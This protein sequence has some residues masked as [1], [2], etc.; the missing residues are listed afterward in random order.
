MSTI[1]AEPV[2]TPAA[3]TAVADHDVAIVGS[4]FSGLAMAVRLLRTGMDDFV[5]LERATDVGGTWR[6]NSYPGCACDVPS[7][8]YSLSFAPNP[9]W[10]STFSPQREIQDYLRSVAAGCGVLA[11]VRFS[12][13]LESAEWDE[14][15]QRWRLATA[16]GPV[17]ARVLILAV[18]PLSEPAIPRLPGLERFTGK[19]FHSAA[20]DHE[21]DLT[22]ERVAVIGTGASAIQFVPQ[23][24]PRVGRLHVFQRTAPWVMPRRARPL[25]RFERAV[26][27]RAPLAQRAMRAGIYWARE[28]YAI[29]LLRA[30][31]APLTKALGRRVLARQVRDPELRRKLTPGYA[32][33]CKRILISNDYLPALTRPNV[34]VVTDGIAEVR[35]RSIVTADGREREVDTIV[36]GTGFRVTD[37]PIAQAVHGRGGRTL[38]EVWQGSPRAHRGTAVAGFP[39]MFFLL[40]PNTGLGHTSVVV[41]A[42]A[43]ADYVTAALLDMRS[44][45]AGAIEVRPEAQQAWNEDV[46]RRMRGTVWTAGGCASW[47]IDRTGANTTLWP[48][49]TVRFRRLMR[50]FDVSGYA[51]TPPAVMQDGAYGTKIPCTASTVLSSRLSMNPSSPPSQT[52]I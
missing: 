39:N 25:S 52:A 23:I 26:Y 15:G 47:Y 5:V 45:L 40:G 51:F 48:G 4:G 24:Q 3:P 49:F 22:G 36:L 13:A 27:R 35:E 6:D 8:L 10:S 33:G 9:E 31:L 29:P 1:T 19:S 16:S 50:R 17:R 14:A 18:G 43:Q 12:S 38:D 30:A 34:E 44:R 46:Q 21:H 20:W 11:H 42:E 2:Q 32:P 7:H 37:F 41:M 28:L